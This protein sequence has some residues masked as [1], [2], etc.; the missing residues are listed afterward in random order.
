M[1]SAFP[2]FVVSYSDGLDAV[3]AVFWPD[4]MKVW[5]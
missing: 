4:D 3:Q 5:N 1:V 2:A